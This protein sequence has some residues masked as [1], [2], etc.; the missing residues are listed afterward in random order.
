MK[1][2]QE[3]YNVD[4]AIYHGDNLYVLKQYIKTSSIDLV[5]LDPP[6]NS[7][8]KFKPLSGRE[9]PHFDPDEGNDMYGDLWRWDDKAQADF[10]QI[11]NQSDNA[12]ASAMNAFRLL[13]GESGLLAYLVMMAPRLVEMRRVLK[14][15]GSIYL[16]CDQHAGAH[17]RLLLDA[18]FGS[19]NFLNSIIWYYGLGGSSTRYWPRKHDEIIWYSREP[20]KHYFKAFKIPAKSNRMK[21]MSKKA[22]DCWDIPTINNMARERLGYPTQ[23]PEALLER[24]ILS[25]SRE[26]DTVL[27]PFCGSG[28][29]LAVC[30]GNRR[31]GIGIDSNRKA[32]DIT[33]Q[34]LISVKQ[35]IPAIKLKKLDNCLEAKEPIP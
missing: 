2:T 7:S 31:N 25:S 13:V 10:D 35:A 14:S 26:G 34:R 19:A 29:T 27:D 9:Y 22:P 28:T 15:T 24:I 3:S 33:H 32:V 12:L 20:D 1:I 16:H 17:L 21:G 11:T 30:A 18:V 23:K 5:Y 8:Q 6:F 4:L